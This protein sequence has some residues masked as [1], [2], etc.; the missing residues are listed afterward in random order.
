MRPDDVPAP[1]GDRSADLGLL[2]VRLAAHIVRLKPGPAAAL[3]RGPL[4]GEGSA[5]LWQLMA[6]NGIEGRGDDLPKW[7]TIMQAIAILTPR[8]G[9]DRKRSAHDGSKPMGAVLAEANISELRLAR[10][11]ASRGEMRRKLAVRTCRRLA[12][13]ESVRFDLRTL[14]KFILWDNDESQ[15]HWIARHYYRIPAKARD[16]QLGDASK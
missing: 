2:V 12:A 5:A 10:L 8:G 3:R 15:A 4:E 7:G 11:L 1:A 13:S 6:T 16:A 14:A 9:D